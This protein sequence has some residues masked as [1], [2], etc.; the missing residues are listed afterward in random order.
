[1]ELRYLWAANTAIY[2]LQKQL[3]PSSE[4]VVM[5]TALENY[6]LKQPEPIQGC[7]LALK[8]IIM[9][10]DSQITHQR[11]FQ[12]PFFYYKDKKLCFLWVKGK[13]TLLGFVEDKSIYPA[14]AGVK[15][16]N[17]IEMI[18]INPDED[19]PLE[20]ILQ[21]IQERIRLYEQM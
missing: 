16:K 7:L 10:I 15:R 17:G 6:Y 3:P 14:V 11:K 13:K 20:F 12:I 9:G 18:Q 21:T 2:Y 5:I 19:L 4:N 1:M 8:N